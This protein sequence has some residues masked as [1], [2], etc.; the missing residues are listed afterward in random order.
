MRPMDAS[1]HEGDGLSQERAALR[2]GGFVPTGEFAARKRVTQ[3]T[4]ANWINRQGMLAAK[5]DGQPVVRVD[6]GGWRWIEPARAEKWLTGW[7][8]SASHGGKRPG[9]GR[10][11]GMQP[12]PPLLAVGAPEF[13]VTGEVVSP[14]QSAL[15]VAEDRDI[16][17]KGERAE[18]APTGIKAAE[19]RVK[20]ADAEA[21]EIKNARLRGLLVERESVTATVREMCENAKNRL[22]TLPPSAAA[23]ILAECALPAEMRGMVETILAAAVERVRGELERCP[24]LEEGTG[25]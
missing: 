17:P 4:V 13:T 24:L 1:T 11:R 19:L 5:A 3:Q 12:R 20:L 8:P 23:K 18:E 16:S 10:R 9:A 6:A 21:R 2:A 14:P 15:S 22:L 7:G 25:H